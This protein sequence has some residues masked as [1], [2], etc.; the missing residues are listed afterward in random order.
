MPLRTHR[1]AT[2]RPDADFRCG[3]RR[4]RFSG[5]MTLEATDD[6]AEARGRVRA[7][8]AS[9]WALSSALS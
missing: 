6:S 8:M 4:I 3:T 5:F 9:T 7:L 1:D 2:V